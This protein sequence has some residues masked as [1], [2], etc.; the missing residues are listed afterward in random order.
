MQL[1]N[2]LSFSCHDPYDK[3]SE[4]ENEDALDFEEKNGFFRAAIADGAGGAGIFCRD[5][6]RFLVKQQPKKP[7]N[8]ADEASKW[9]I[10]ISRDFFEAMMP[11]IDITDSFIVEKFHNHGSYSTLVFIWLRVDTNELYY[12]GLGDSVLLVFDEV[13]G[14]SLPK[15]IYPITE[16]QRIDQPPKLINWSK[17]LGNVE[18]KM[19][20]VQSGQRII[21][22]TDGLGR[23]LIELLTMLVPSEML[24]V[25][26]QPLFSSVNENRDLIEQLR[27]KNEFDSISTLLDYIQTGLTRPKSIIRSNLI[28]RIQLGELD[29]D[30]LTILM[31]KI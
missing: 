25:L 2:P 28:S 8:S 20:K 14:E 4:S 5:W 24:N 7:F 19:I 9:F 3:E 6:S 29:R 13:N 27:L 12:W 17:Q 16:Q 30:D 26:G 15:L 11:S 31:W 18:I 23:W 1:I 22:A 21:M 10:G